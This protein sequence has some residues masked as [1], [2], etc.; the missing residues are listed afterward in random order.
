MT[1]SLSGGCGESQFLTL[2][3]FYELGCPIT[4]NNVMD[5]PNSE[6]HGHAFGTVTFPIIN[7][8]GIITNE[9]YL[10]DATYRQFFTVLGN[11]F[12]RYYDLKAKSA[13]PDAGYFTIQ[14]KE[15]RNFAQALLKNGYITLSLENIKIYGEGF[16]LSLIPLRDIAKIPEAKNIPATE[17]MQSLTKKTGEFDYS[18]KEIREWLLEENILFDTKS[19]DK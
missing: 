11:H 9:S 3:P 2:Y 6:K 10:V 7:E 1:D 17:Y 5:F 14:T 8:N 12:G 18:E 15:G 4:I 16:S 19:L 13:A